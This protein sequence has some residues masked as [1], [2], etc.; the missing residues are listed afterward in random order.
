MTTSLEALAAYI[1]WTLLLA[2]MLIVYRSSMVMSKKRLADAWT[3][4]RDAEDPELMKRISGAFMN[5]L[6]TGPLFFAVILLAHVSGQGSVTDSLA[7]LYVGARVVQSVS[8]IISTQHWMVFLIRF[9]AF[10]V[11]VLLL[12]WWLL[13]LTGL[14]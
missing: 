7:M 8:H 5:T 3:R 11:Q 6:E 9:P 13:S 1:A 10:L 12:A 4:G 14:M 2:S